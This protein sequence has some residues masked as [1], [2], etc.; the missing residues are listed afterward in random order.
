MNEMLSTSQGPFSAVNWNRPEDAYTK[1]FWDQNVRQFW[2]DEEI[3]LADDK[4]SWMT[5]APEEKRA[6]EEVLAG[7]AP[8]THATAVELAWIPDRIRGFGPV[9]ERFLAHAKRREA[10]LLQAFRARTPLPARPTARAPDVAVIA[11]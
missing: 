9:K 8:E 2:V 3:P 10:E 1:M 5:L 4:L 6:Y 11:G 7:L